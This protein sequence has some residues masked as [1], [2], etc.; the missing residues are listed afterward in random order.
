MLVFAGEKPYMLSH[1]TGKESY[2]MIMLKL[3]D[4]EIEEFSSVSGGNP[5]VIKIGGTA[6]VP[7]QLEKD[8]KPGSVTSRFY[9]AESGSWTGTVALRLFK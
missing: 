2:F 4:K 6:F 1:G 9:N 3:S 8:L 5:N 7:L